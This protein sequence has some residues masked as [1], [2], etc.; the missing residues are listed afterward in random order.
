MTMSVAGDPDS[1]RG[2]SGTLR[3][4]FS[5][6][7]RPESDHTPRQGS[8]GGSGVSAGFD[9]PHHAGRSGGAVLFV[10]VACAGPDQGVDRAA[11]ALLIR[12]DLHRPGEGLVQGSRT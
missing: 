7:G 10:D 8:T 6:Q 9:A 3:Y 5:M 11:A 12:S 2:G 4:I 1:V